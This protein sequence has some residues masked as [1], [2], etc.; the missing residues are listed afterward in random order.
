[1][2]GA[3]VAVFTLASSLAGAVPDGDRVV[4]F[5]GTGVAGLAGDGGQALDALLAAPVAV[6]EV[7]GGVLVA[8]AQTHTVRLVD[9]GS[10]RISRF[11][12]T[13]AAGTSAAGTPATQAM[14]DAPSAVAV[15]PNGDVYIADAG[16]DRVL[17]VDGSGSTRVVAGTGVRGD[18]LRGPRGLAVRPNGDVVVADTGHHRLR[19]IDHASGEATTLAPDAKLQGPTGLALLPN[20]TVFVADTGNHRIVRI[21]PDGTVATVAGTGEPGHDGDGGAATAASFRAPEGVAVG[22]DGSLLVADTG[23]HVVRH[24]DTGGTVRTVAGT[25]GVAGDQ[26]DHGLASAARLDSPSG[27]AEVG[28]RVVLADTGNHRLRA[29]VPSIPAPT[30]AAVVPEPPANDNAP[31]VM[32]DAPAGTTVRLYGNSDCS[33]SVL[34]EGPAVSFADGLRASVPDDSRTTIHAIA[35]DGQGVASPCSS[36]SVTYV[37]DSTPPPTPAFTDGPASP[38][39][40]VTPTWVFDSEGTARCRLSGPAGT[41]VEGDCGS[42]WTSPSSMHP[43]GEYR[44]AVRAVD[45]AGNESEPATRSFVL[46]TSPPAPPTIALQPI[47]DGFEDRPL[48]HVRAGTDEEVECR[49][50]GSATPWSPWEACGPTWTVTLDDPAS[51]TWVLEARATDAAGNTGPAASS[52]YAYERS[53][54]GP[55]PDPAHPPSDGGSP[56]PVDPPQVGV[57]APVPTTPRS[58]GVVDPERAPATGPAPQASPAEDEGDATRPAPRSVH[59]RRSIALA[60]TSDPDRSVSMSVPSVPGPGPRRSF[61]AVLGASVSRAGELVG[62][63]VDEAA[64]PVLL[65]LLVLVYLG[66]QDRVDRRDPKL[67]MAPAAEPELGFPEHP[68]A[69]PRGLTRCWVARHLPDGGRR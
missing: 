66:V 63:H 65:L 18:V 8:D 68:T 53:G 17:A 6:T 15:R 44:L 64:F 59:P 56:A 11:A 4:P 7:G 55:G 24:V 45:A 52:S 20:G 29:L 47:E 34:G 35:V 31:V 39:S 42:P 51:Q 54:A 28:G 27:V 46:D 30:V 40:D 9:L 43:D 5:A 25:P 23:N 49:F 19:V 32:G 41:V 57:A 21:G 22:A 36:T 3:W 58:P 61:T 2:A 60:Q 37:E 13:G 16:N 14:L 48:W 33:G 10:G 38:S 62:D 1:M 26:G 67:A 12:G 69:A 50:G